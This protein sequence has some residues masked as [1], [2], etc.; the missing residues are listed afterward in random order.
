MIASKPSLTAHFSLRGFILRTL[1]YLIPAF[2]FWYHAASI[3]CWPA[4]ALANL[5]MPLF[6]PDIVTGLEQNGYLVEVVTTL[7]AQTKQ[8]E[9]GQLVFSLN[10]LQYGYGL[11]LLTAMTLATNQSP[12]QKMDTLTYGFILIIMVQTWSL[13]FD[14]ATNLL[15]KMEGTYFN[16]ITE[17]IPLY[18]EPIVLNGIGLGYQLGFLILPAVVPIVYWVLRHQPFLKQITV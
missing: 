1:F 14:V 18:A 17:A 15:L 4:I 12:Y 6:M 13:C 7:A 9:V 10:A 16:T 8:G 2:F 3:V 5:L 11:P